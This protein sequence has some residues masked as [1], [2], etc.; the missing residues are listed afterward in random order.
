MGRKSEEW[1]YLTYVELLGDG[2]LTGQ[3]LAGRGSWGG[4]SERMLDA[5]ASPGQ[6]WQSTTH[7]L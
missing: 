7:T 1:N 4:M 5:A 6:K 3:M 2:D